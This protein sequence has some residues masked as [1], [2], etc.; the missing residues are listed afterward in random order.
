[1]T[2]PETALLCTGIVT[3]ICAVLI[4]AEWLFP[5]AGVVRAR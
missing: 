1:M 3:I 5:L 2:L 4:L